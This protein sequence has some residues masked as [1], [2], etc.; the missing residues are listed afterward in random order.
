MKKKPK[1]RKPPVPSKK[2]KVHKT[3]KDYTRSKDT[4]IEEMLKI[5]QE[6]GF[7]EGGF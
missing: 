3:K 6:D 5:N 7:Y 1:L 4:L 2:N